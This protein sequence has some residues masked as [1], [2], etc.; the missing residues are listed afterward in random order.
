MSDFKNG[1]KVTFKPGPKAASSV[2]ATV[3]GKDGDF[4]VTKDAA[5]KQRK[6]RPGACKKAA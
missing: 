3:T 2:T 1:D 4:L 5:G 6:I